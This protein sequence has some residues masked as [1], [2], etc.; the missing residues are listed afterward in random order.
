MAPQANQ[1]ILSLV[2]D[3]FFSPRV[4]STARSLGMQTVLIESSKEVASPKAFVERVSSL[5][6]ALIILDLNA[7]LPWAEWLEAVKAESG[8]AAIPWLAFGSHK[9]VETIGRAKQLGADRVV[10]KSRFTV[11]MP[12]L[13]RA[14]IDK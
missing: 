9:D 2:S 1:L 10:A 5:L 13:I 8:L 11:E 12:E 7:A 4:A 14:L 6:P 3:L